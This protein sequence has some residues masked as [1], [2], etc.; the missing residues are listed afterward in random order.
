M[1]RVAWPAAS[2]S[3][4]CRNDA[5]KGP[6]LSRWTSLPVTSAEVPTAYR[7]I[8]SVPSSGPTSSRA[9]PSLQVRSK[10]ANFSFAAYSAVRPP[11]SWTTSK[12]L[13]R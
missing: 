10:S 3:E 8:L 7:S 5:S 1:N 9:P 2:G 12:K 4:R 11:W 6:R 13:A